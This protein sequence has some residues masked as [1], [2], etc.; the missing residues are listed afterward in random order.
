MR[1]GNAIK[2]LRK[3]KYLSQ[4]ELAKKSNL[5]QTYLSQIENDKKEPT[6]SSLKAIVTQLETSLP[7]IFILALNE[8][9]IREEHR[10]KY[11]DLQPL[12]E[13]ALKIVL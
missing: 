5:S 3:Q 9:D 6:L 13:E 2:Q 8:Q 12:L 4:G 10:D 1:L 7:A 11:E